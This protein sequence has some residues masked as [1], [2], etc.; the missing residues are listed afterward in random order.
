MIITGRNVYDKS[1]IFKMISIFYNDSLQKLLDY[2][3]KSF[4]VTCDKDAIE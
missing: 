4:I 2:S 3:F 1:T